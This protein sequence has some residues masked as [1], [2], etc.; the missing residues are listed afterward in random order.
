LIEIKPDE[1]AAGKQPVS[2]Q[3]AVLDEYQNGG[4]SPSYS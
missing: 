1:F 2:R 3:F 4:L